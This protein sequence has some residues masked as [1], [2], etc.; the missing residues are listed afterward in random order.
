MFSS[1]EGNQRELLKTAPESA[2]ILRYGVKR[3][4]A[5]WLMP[6]QYERKAGAGGNAH[7]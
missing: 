7:I 4:P 3:I 1:G 2:V 6:V 5:P